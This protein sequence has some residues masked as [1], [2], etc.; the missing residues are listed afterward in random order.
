VYGAN[1]C[2][3]AWTGAGRGAWYRIDTDCRAGGFP[4]TAITTCFGSVSITPGSSPTTLGFYQSYGVFSTSTGHGADIGF[5]YDLDSTLWGSVYNDE[6]TGYQNGNVTVVPPQHPCVNVTLTALDGAVSMNVTDALSGKNLGCDLWTHV[7]PQLGLNSNG[8]DI[9]WYR[10]DSIAQDPP[11]TL[12][13]GVGLQ[14]AVERDWMLQMSQSSGDWVVA[15]PHLIAPNNS[16]FAPGPC[17]S[18]AERS[19]ITVHASGTLQYSASNVS[20]VYPA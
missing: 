10:F 14:R 11:E 19:T 6:V 18:P 15:G 5:A 12:R 2:S 4:A 13:G 7:D 16:G 20:I 17:C 9:G 3:Q 1:T 8:T